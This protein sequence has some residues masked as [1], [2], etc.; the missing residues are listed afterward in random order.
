MTAVTQKDPR[1]GV[2]NEARW[3]E[4]VEA[5][6]GVFGEKGFRAATLQDIASKVGMLRG[7]LYYYIEGKEDLVFEIV[8]RGHL[9]GIRFVQE[10]EIIAAADPSTRLAALIRRWM[11]G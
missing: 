1:P 6:T 4:I 11:E 10:D 7:S 5:A 9:R 8:R 3:E 2:L